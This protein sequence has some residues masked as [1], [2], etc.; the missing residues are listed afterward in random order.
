MYC[1]IIFVLHKKTG[2][3]SANFFGNKLSFVFANY[4]IDHLLSC[5]F[6]LCEYIFLFPK[7]IT[8]KF[9]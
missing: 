5:L 4:L 2:F 9:A 3:I 7:T 6:F 1:L 8:I